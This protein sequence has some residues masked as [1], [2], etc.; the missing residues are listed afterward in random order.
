M[1]F[2][3]LFSGTATQV[4]D[5]D[6]GMQL[7][8]FILSTLT[9]RSES[10]RILFGP[11]EVDPCMS[12]YDERYAAWLHAELER[13]RLR[14]EALGT[15]QAGHH[16]RTRRAFGAVETAS[17]DDNGR[18]TLP[19]MMRRRT[20]IGE[21]ALVIGAGGRFE[22]WNPEIARTSGDDELRQLAAFA[23]GDGDAIQ[24]SEVAG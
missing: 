10:R 11:H 7:P 14:D 23:L 20:R 6:G 15:D 5:A 3:S 24:E 17:Y 21:A 16:A 1:A 8:H 22:I 9:R 13:L 12:G 4:V 18:V 2:D 19:P